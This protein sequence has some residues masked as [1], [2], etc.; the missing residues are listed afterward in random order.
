MIIGFAPVSRE[1]P[2]KQ[3][4][5]RCEELQV[6]PQCPVSERSAPDPSVVGAYWHDGDRA[7][8]ASGKPVDE[9]ELVRLRRAAQHRPLPSSEFELNRRARLPVDRNEKLVM[10]RVEAD[11]DLAAGGQLSRLLLIDHHLVRTPLR[12]TFAGRLNTYGRML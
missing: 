6:T 7:L 10:T 2:D 4:Q 5:S 1:Q 3:N 9:G 11:L 12:H 8:A